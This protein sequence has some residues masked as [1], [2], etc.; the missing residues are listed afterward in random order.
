MAISA[1]DA[2]TP[3][4]RAWIAGW[5]RSTCAISSP[6]PLQL[7]LAAVLGACPGGGSANELGADIQAPA[8]STQTLARSLVLRPAHASLAISLRWH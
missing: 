6:N 7:A 5:L 2:S 8:T 3:L 1:C 4:V